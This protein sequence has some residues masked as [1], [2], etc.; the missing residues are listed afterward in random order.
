ME[1]LSFQL[2]HDRHALVVAGSE[3][4]TDRAGEVLQVLGGFAD[5]DEISVGGRR[6]HA[7]RLYGTTTIGYLA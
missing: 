3:P 7:C 2:P 6:R 1:L 4:V 5:D